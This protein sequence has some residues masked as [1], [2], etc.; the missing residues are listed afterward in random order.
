M[1]IVPIIL[2]VWAAHE[3]DFAEL[4]PQDAGVLHKRR[5]IVRS[6]C[7]RQPRDAPQRQYRPAVHCV[8]TWEARF[9]LRS[10]RACACRYEALFPRLADDFPLLFRAHTQH[11]SFEAYTWARLTIWSRS[12]GSIGQTSKGE[13]DPVWAASPNGLQ[14]VWLLLFVRAQR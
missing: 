11:F 10:Y 1:P 12:F 3:V 4:S 7:V 14:C 13:Y 8:R 5:A 2:Q 6:E 9:I